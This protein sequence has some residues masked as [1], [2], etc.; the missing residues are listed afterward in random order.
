MVSTTVAGFSLQD[1]SPVT[2]RAIII[3]SALGS[4]PASS[5]RIGC[6]IVIPSKAAVTLIGPYPG[7]SGSQTVVRGLL[8]LS[9]MQSLEYCH[10][11]M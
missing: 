10:E 11:Y 6:G 4:S 2:G 8:A 5:D 9:E 1:M 3:K 7:Y